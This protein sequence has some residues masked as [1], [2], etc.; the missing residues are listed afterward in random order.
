MIAPFLTDL[1]ADAR[2]RSGLRSNPAITDAQIVGL[3]N[4][5]YSELNDK[6]VASNQHWG[7]KSV[8]FTLTGNTAGSNTF[9]LTTIPD[10]QSDQGVNYYPGGYTQKPVT[11]PL[12]SSFMERN[13]WGAY[14]N[15]GR[16]REYFTNGDTLF[17]NPFTNSAGQY[18]LIYNP[19]ATGFALPIAISV[20]TVSVSVPVVSGHTGITGGLTFKAND[21]TPADIFLP[22]DLGD[23]L[24]FT[25]CTNVGNDGFWTIGGPGVISANEVGFSVTTGLV[26]ETFPD[27]ATVTLFRQSNVTAAGVWTF[28]GANQFTATTANVHV[29]DTM[30]VSGATNSG[31]FVVTGV[32]LNTVTTAATGLVAE[33]FAAGTVT[34]TVQPANTISQ[35]PAIMSP[36]ALF[37][38]LKV[39]IAIKTSRNQPITELQADLAP[40]LLRL[41]AMSKKRSDGV[42]QAPVTRHRFGGRSYR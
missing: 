36:W 37:L 19:Q 22:T 8:R 41:T 13:D 11:V 9:D 18:E 30:T 34:V 12:M 1:I 15:L 10:F 2:V 42:Q 16:G 20:Q 23:F 29:G 6:F 32:G 28:Y 31:S 27:N 5:A 39:S 40:Q 14:G 35:L 17:V 26:S 7:R 3:Y 25:G 38:K 4:D 33:N 21:L 24:E